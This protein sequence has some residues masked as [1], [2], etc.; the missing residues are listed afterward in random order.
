MPKRIVEVLMGALQKGRG[1]ANTR[2]QESPQPWSEMLASKK[3][4]APKERSKDYFRS[5]RGTRGTFSLPNRT[6]YRWHPKEEAGEMDRGDREGRG[7]GGGEERGGGGGSR[8][9]A[10]D[11]WTEEDFKQRVRER[12]DR[13]EGRLDRIEGRGEGPSGGRGGGGRGGRGRGGG[14]GEGR[15][16]GGRDGGR[17]DRGGG[18]GGGG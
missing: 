13:I 4:G 15:G 3:A 18:R 11:Q 1:A 9:G 8:G 16:G 5:P 6:R 7:G 14:R 10:E 17:G 12:L 2:L